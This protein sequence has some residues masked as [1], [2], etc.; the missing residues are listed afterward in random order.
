M[1]NRLKKWLCKNELKDYDSYINQLELVSREC[2][3][4]YEKNQELLKVN[5]EL[6]NTVADYKDRIDSYKITIRDLSA[7]QTYR[8]VEPIV[9]DNPTF[10]N[11]RDMNWA[12]GNAIVY[13][14]YTI[15]L[16]S[17]KYGIDAED[18]ARVIA[19]NQWVSNQE[20]IADFYDCDNFAVALLSV[21]NQR[22]LSSFAFGIAH[23][24]TH[25]FNVFLDRDLVLW[26]VE[27]QHADGMITKY[28]EIKHN[29][30]YQ[31]N[32]LSI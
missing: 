14:A 18:V 1:L 25:A 11:V 3:S 13:F 6:L 9:Y 32:F 26:V 30:L 2:D 19:H 12:I 4:L 23:S 31:I 15:I 20:Y 7:K 16:D 29:P 21:F 22:S 8:T 27:P 28:E 17:R 24:P 5:N 10:M